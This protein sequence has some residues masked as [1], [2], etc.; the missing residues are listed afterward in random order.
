MALVAEGMGKHWC[1]EV[2]RKYI[3]PIPER[4]ANVIAAKD[5]HTNITIKSLLKQY[6][7]LQLIF[8]MLISTISACFM[9]VIKQNHVFKAKKV[10][11]VRS[12]RCSNHFGQHCM[13]GFRSKIKDTRLK[14]DMLHVKH[15]NRKSPTDW[16]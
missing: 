10:N 12:V 13:C 6:D 7:S 9:N 15:H 14:V 1:L 8:V 4:C 3:D 16:R 11:M 5:C 2:L